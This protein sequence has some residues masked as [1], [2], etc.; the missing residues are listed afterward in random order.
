MR[1]QSLA[2]IAF[3]AWAVPLSSAAQEVPRAEVS[4]GYSWARHDGEDMNGWNASATLNLR[5][6]IGLSADVSGL[7]SSVGNT[8]RARYPVLA[9]PRVS[10]RWGRFAPF[11][12]AL[13][14]ALHTRSHLEF[15]TVSIAECETDPMMALGGGLGVRLSDRWA[16][17]VKADAAIVR[18]RGRTDQSPR[19]SGGLVLRIG[20]LR[21]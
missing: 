11:A 3:V 18:S 14:G 19:L 17:E 15:L 8:D 10:L 21:R 20:E 7:Y 2:L 16:G 6:W 13:A 5:E 9:G 12:Y 4:G 1:Y